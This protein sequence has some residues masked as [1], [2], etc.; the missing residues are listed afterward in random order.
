MVLGEHVSGPDEEQCVV[1]DREPIAAQRTQDRGHER[2]DDDGGC[3][4]PDSPRRL[5]DDVERST[6]VVLIAVNLVGDLAVD[7]GVGEVRLGHV[8]A[9]LSE[10][11]P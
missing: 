7:V 9:R 3:G 8:G 5:A 2:D 10:R 4:D 11:R 6:A 1:A